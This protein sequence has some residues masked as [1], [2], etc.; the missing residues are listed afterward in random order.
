LDVKKVNWPDCKS[1]EEFYNLPNWIQ[2]ECVEVH[3]FGKIVQYYSWYDHIDDHIIQQ[4]NSIQQ[5]KYPKNINGAMISRVGQDLFFGTSDYTQDQKSLKRYIDQEFTDTRN[6]IINT[7][8]HSD[9]T[10]C[11]IAPGLIISSPEIPTYK[12]KFPDW[13]VFYLKAPDMGGMKPFSQLKRKNYGKW[14]I[15]GFEQDQSVIDTVETWLGHW[16]GYVEETV[17]DVNMLIVDPKNVL[18]VNYNKELFDC[19]ERYGITAHVVPF[20]HRFFWDGG[21][22]CVTSDL[23]RQGTKK[24]FFPN[25]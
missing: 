2:Q 18:V 8:G 25:Q 19:L 20:R 13:E 15:P 12:H 9:S 5:T 4:G 14:W 17:F 10:F 21:L 11:L 3:D 16:T 1:L 22:H 7:G 6:H 24:D 23:H